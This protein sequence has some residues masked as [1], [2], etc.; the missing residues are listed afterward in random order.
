MDQQIDGTV[1]ST[2]GKRR[3]DRILAADY[4]D[5]LGTCSMVELRA[6]R[7]DAEQEEVDLSYMRRLVQGRIDLLQ[8]E[9]AQRANAGDGRVMDS[10]SAILAADRGDTF[11]LGRHSVL[12][13]S[14]VDEHR[15]YVER[16][17][18]DVDV[19]N[20]T[21]RTD[22]QLRDGIQKLHAEERRVSDQRR[23]VQVVVDACTAEL[24]RRYRDGEADVSD[25]LPAE[26]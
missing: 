24:T 18:S 17:V 9:L 12:T 3:I 4:L 2:P 15:R 7:A 22:D 20:I 13:P 14:R 21:E 25:L 16:L 6:L 8:A 11:G 23:A 26:S 19:S 5:T 10:L 1:E